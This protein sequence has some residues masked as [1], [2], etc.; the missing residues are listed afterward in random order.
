[1]QMNIELSGKSW[2]V[3]GKRFATLSAARDYLD[4]VENLKAAP[5]ACASKPARFSKP[6]C[7]A[8]PRSIVDA[9]RAAFTRSQSPTAS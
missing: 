3:N 7:V 6:A 1:M 5:Y 4:G 2:L 9:L 8:K